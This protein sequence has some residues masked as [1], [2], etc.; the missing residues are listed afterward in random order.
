MDIPTKIEKL[1]ESLLVIND[2]LQKSFDKID[3]LEKEILFL[4]NDK[5]NSDK[6][7]FMNTLEDYYNNQEVNFDN[8]IVNRSISLTPPPIERQK[9]F[10]HE[11]Y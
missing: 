2:M 3:L 5:K 9:A 10:S 7:V 4:K 11:L 6:N 1:E 8:I